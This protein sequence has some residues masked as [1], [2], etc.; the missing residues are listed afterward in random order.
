M[1]SKLETLQ[2]IRNKLVATIG[3]WK[4]PRTLRSIIYSDETRAVVTITG[5]LKRNFQ[6]RSTEEGQRVRAAAEAIFAKLQE[7]PSE[8][9]DERL[10]A[11]GDGV[12]HKHFGITASLP[13]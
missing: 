5:V 6:I 3:I 1:I 4:K 7:P 8:S 9:L 2:M 12:P 10:M 11:L 13:E